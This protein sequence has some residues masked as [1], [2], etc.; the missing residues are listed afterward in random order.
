M[1]INRRD[2]ASI[3]NHVSPYPERTVPVP[4]EYHMT[5]S[6]HAAMV[7]SMG[8]NEALV[9]LG[10][11][12]LYDRGLALTLGGT[13]LDLR[14]SWTSNHFDDVEYVYN[15][16]RGQNLRSTLQNA[17]YNMRENFRRMTIDP[18]DFIGADPIAEMRRD[19]ERFGD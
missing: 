1:F 18:N 11:D 16:S 17:N 19:A 10:L 4:I 6:I 3:N 2:P 9:Q 15:H 14:Q 7:C 5:H 8:E 12:F 13:T